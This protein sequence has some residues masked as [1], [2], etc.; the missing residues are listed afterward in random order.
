MLSI[1]FSRKGKKKY[2]V[3]RL[4]VTDKRRDPFGDY[5]DN[6]GTYNPHTKEAKLDIDRI[7]SWL[8]KGAQATATVHNLLISKEI[9]K[10]DKVRASKSKPG[11]KKKAQLE[12]K[13]AEE[14]AAKKAQ[15]EEA[16][17][18]KEAAEQAA[19]API[20]NSAPAEE[21]VKEE[22]KPAEEKT[23]EQQA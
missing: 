1:R 5:L 21:A 15:E 11:K 2:P 13:K 8:E 20:E 9:V 18:A 16:K 17:K 14:A 6:L 12:I 23:E 7:K 22:P 10:A 4:I 19:T 3:Y